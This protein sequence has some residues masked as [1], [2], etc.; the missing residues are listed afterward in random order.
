MELRESDVSK[1][2]HEDRADIAIFQYEAVKR[3]V[4]VHPELHPVLRSFYERI[5]LNVS[6]N[7]T[8]LSDE[9]L[10]HMLNKNP[11]VMKILSC[12]EAAKDVAREVANTKPRATERGDSKTDREKVRKK[13]YMT[14]ADMLLEVLSLARKSGRD[15]TF[16][17]IEKEITVSAFGCEKHIQDLDNNELD[18]MHRAILIYQG[19]GV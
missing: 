6:I 11:D 13:K 17:D 15:I 19:Q 3:F 2:D 14:I 5:M 4:D 18:L 12:D 8:P 7:M 16:L 1:F 10:T 9:L